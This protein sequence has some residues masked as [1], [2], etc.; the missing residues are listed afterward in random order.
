MS[1]PT[2]RKCGA[3]TEH[4]DTRGRFRSGNPG[5]R[6]GTR[7]KA[8]HAALTVMEGGAKRLAKKAVDLAMAGD[9]AALR[10]CLERLAPPARE[11]TL[12]VDLPLPT[13]PADVPETLRAI[14][15]AAAAGAITASEAERLSTCVEKF[16]RVHELADF[17]LRLRALEGRGAQ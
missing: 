5:K 3:N 16:A 6:P 10:L 14:L 1:T 12:Q 4:R 9:V 7:H 17:D 2:D 15:Q 8:T 11:R 13:S